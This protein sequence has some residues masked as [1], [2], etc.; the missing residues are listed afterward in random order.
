MIEIKQLQYLAVCARRRSISRA[1]EE[2][3]TTQPN[4]S[5]VIKSLEEEL[6]FDLFV[7]QGQG[8]RLTRRGQRVYEYACRI[9]ENVEGLLS[10]AGQDQVEELRV[11]TNPSS[12]MAAR[13]T[14]FYTENRDADVCFYFMAASV[15]DII[16]RCASGQDQ[17]GFVHVMEPQMQLFQYRLG[18]NHLEYEELKRVKA[19]LYFSRHNPLSKARSLEEIPMERLRLVQCYGGEFTLNHYWDLENQE[20]EELLEQKVSVVTNSDYLMNK[21]L[22]HT[23]LGNVSGDY[24]SGEMAEMS[25][26]EYSGISLYGDET[27]VSFGYIK[28]KGEKLGEWAEKLAAFVRERL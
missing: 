15:E 12:W 14:E 5:K 24:L 25:A 1:A 19:M 7:R 17:L 27:P 2:L 9:L 10:F 20:K 21:L 22:R 8:I 11:S 3:Y 4:V 26:E 28:K 13:L 6:G 18:K 23:D 16:K